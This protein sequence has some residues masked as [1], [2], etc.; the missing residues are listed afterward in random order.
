MEQMVSTSSTTTSFNGAAPRHVGKKGPSLQEV[1]RVS[2]AQ[3]VVLAATSVVWA[4]NRRRQH[5]A[6]ASPSPGASDGLG[7]GLR[8]VQPDGYSAHEV[9]KGGRLGKQKCN[10]NFAK[11]E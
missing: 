11:Q 2:L 1:R 7:V 3:E 4:E 10:L 5:S 8:R 9:V 6:D